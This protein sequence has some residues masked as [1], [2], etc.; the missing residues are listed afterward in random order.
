MGFPVVKGVACILAHVPD[1]IPLGSKP[2]REIRRDANLLGELKRHMRTYEEGVPGGE[3]SMLRPPDE[4][5][6]TYD[7]AA[8]SREGER[9]PGNTGFRYGDWGR[10]SK[11]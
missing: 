3:K 9:D 1:L 7:A 4:R 5:F 6:G 2:L 11:R 8:R 10:R